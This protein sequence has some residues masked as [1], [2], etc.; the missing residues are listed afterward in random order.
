MSPGGRILNSLRSRPLE[1]PSSV[2]VTT[3]VKSPTGGRSPVVLEAGRSTVLECAAYFLRPRRRVDRPVP[4]PIATTRSGREL[5]SLPSLAR[6]AEE[7]LAGFVP[8]PRL[9][10]LEG[11]T[12]QSYFKP[13][14]STGISES[15]GRR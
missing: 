3:A 8:E 5:A 12:G 13:Q 14:P 9:M 2:T 11:D 1:P 6:S 7:G 4:P 10:M 15:K